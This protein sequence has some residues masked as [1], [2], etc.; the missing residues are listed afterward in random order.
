MLNVVEAA[1]RAEGDQ[2]Q[3]RTP[4]IVLGREECLNPRISIYY[5]TGIKNSK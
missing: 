2:R 1:V 5:S 3:V 4:E